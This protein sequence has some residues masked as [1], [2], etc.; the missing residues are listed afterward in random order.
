V[1]KTFP[2]LEAIYCRPFFD[3]LQESRRIHAAH[4][5]ENE[6]QLCTLLSVKTGGCSE[7]CA[8]CAQ[9]SRYNTGLA[10]EKLM[11]AERTDQPAFAWVL[12]GEECVTGIGNSTK[13]SKL[14]E[15]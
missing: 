12:P 9:S 2:E 11:S 10:R 1:R 15:P 8:Y 5:P 13:C 6:M 7:D 14:S 4:W 3:L